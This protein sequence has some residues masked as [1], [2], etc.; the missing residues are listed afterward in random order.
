MSVLCQRYGI[1]RC[2]HSIATTD[3]SLEIRD[4]WLGKAKSK[5]EAASLKS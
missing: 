3:R 2:F 1:A 4:M 5:E